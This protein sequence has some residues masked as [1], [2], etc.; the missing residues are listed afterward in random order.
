MAAQLKMSSCALPILTFHALDDEPAVTSFSPRMFRR[1][2]ARLHEN[3]YRTLRLSEAEDCLRNRRSFPSRSI[4]ITFDDGYQSVY[5][6][7]L[8]VLRDYAMG[9]TVFLTVG[10]TPAAKL[11]DRLP[12]L[13]GRSMLSW[14][15][16]REMSKV[17]I[18][19]G[20]HTL[21]HPDLT[22]LPAD[23]VEA[24]IC[25]SKAVIEDALGDPVRCF[26]YPFGRYDQRSREIVQRHFACACSDKLGLTTRDSDLYALERVDAYYLRTD[27]LFDLMLTRW[28][29]WYVRAR[30]VP[31]RIR[32]AVQLS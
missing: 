4:V 24:E 5:K 10:E 18:D 1:G 7:A 17:K 14:A 29:P 3:G 19:F 2:M 25:R 22:R 11:G 9:A 28:F 8:P 27:R 13:S 21:T 23:R 16:I 6:E 12:S 15:E 26:A 31:R 32:R 30:S 20:A